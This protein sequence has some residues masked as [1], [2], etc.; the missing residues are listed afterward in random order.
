MASTLEA[1]ENC[2]PGVP[3]VLSHFPV[4]VRHTLQLTLGPTVLGLPRGQGSRGSVLSRALA[5]LSKHL[6]Q[7]WTLPRAPREATAWAES[8]EEEEEEQEEEEEEKGEEEEEEEEACY[9]APSKGLI[10]SQHGAGCFHF[11]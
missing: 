10:A 5:A 4:S 9:C 6:L 7:T 8:E 1:L 11:H 2:G 3:W